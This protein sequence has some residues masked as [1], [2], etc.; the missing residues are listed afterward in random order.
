[1][2]NLFMVAEIYIVNENP[3]GYPL[4]QE[5]VGVLLRVIH[6]LTIFQ[7]KIFWQERH[8]IINHA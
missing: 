5:L 6:T 3:G 2:I 1:M 4:S 7:K 8:C